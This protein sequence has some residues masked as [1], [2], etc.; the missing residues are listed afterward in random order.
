MIAVLDYGMGNLRSVEKALEH[1]GAQA[2]VTNDRARIRAA[3]GLVLPGVGAF[4]KAMARIDELGLAQDVRDALDAGVPVLGICLGLQLLFDS[5]TEIGGARGMS[6]VHGEV[7]K[8][9]AGGLKL[10]Q[11][12]WNAVAW[13]R[14]SPLVEGLPNPC[15]MYHVH[16]YAP[17][18]DSAVE[19]LGSATYGEEFVTAIERGPL[20]GVQF[21]P[22][23]SGRHGLRLLA[24]FARICSGE[25]RAAA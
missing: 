14:E 7:D 5:S 6:F 9:R 15:P 8:L 22:E 17:R 11:I 4:P 18:P 16:T 12:G 3:A 2:V 21:H 19:V 23:K 13:Q 20:Y 24:N 1:V 10:P 25:L